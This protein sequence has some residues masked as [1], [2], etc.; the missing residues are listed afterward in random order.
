ME[1][2][3]GEDENRVVPLCQVDELPHTVV[4]DET[5]VHNQTGNVGDGVDGDILVL[6][7]AQTSNVDFD[8]V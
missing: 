5:N 3:G 4:T 2:R 1:G 8:V 7:V 6:A